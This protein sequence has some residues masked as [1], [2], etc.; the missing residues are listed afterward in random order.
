MW[1]ELSRRE[2]ET[3]GKN[4]CSERGACS[5]EDGSL[6]LDDPRR[7]GR[8][9]G[10]PAALLKRQ[11]WG[12]RGFLSQDAQAP[13]PL[14]SLIGAPQAWVITTA[15]QCNFKTALHSCCIFKA[16]IIP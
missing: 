16:D 2:A 3:Y 15:N 14:A 11:S 5:P 4:I 8:F 9:P 6:R 7:G 13:P 12:F 1:S 10:R